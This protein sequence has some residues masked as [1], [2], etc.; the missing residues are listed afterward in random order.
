M[1]RGIFLHRVTC[2]WEH[3]TICREICATNFL[4]QDLLTFQG[5]CWYTVAVEHCRDKPC[6]A[7]PAPIYSSITMASVKRRMAEMFLNAAACVN[8]ENH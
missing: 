8:S 4:T 2:K 1:C 7:V 6:W 3:G 5:K